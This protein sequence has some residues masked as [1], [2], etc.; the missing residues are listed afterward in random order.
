MS[1]VLLKSVTKMKHFATLIFVLAFGIS[2]AHGQG[3]GVELGPKL[4]FDVAGDVEEPFIG[5]DARL[6]TSLPV[7]INPVFDYY[8]AEENLTIWHIG[9]N[10]LYE[11]GIDNEMFT[12]YAG[13]GLG[14]TRWSVDVDTGFGDFDSSDSSVGLNGVAGARFAVGNVNLFGQAQLTFGDIDVVALAVGAL[15]ALGGR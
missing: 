5:V 15:F 4:G 2:A 1:N 11:F 7:I 8:F 12:P 6:T 9:V 14:I 13:G 3:I 10:A